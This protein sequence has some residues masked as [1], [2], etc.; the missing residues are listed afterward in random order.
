ML[1]A[2]DLGGTKTLLGLFQRS[3]RARPEE[4]R[5]LEFATLEYPGAE[6][7]IREFLEATGVSPADVEAAS[8]G[9]PGPVID[10]RC[11]P[12]NVDWTVDARSLM[13]ELGL[14]RVT[15]LNDLEA[16]AH[17]VPFLR[18]DELKVLQEGRRD[19]AG[20]AALLAAGTGLGLALLINVDGELRPSASEGGHADF[21]ARTPREIELLIELTRIYGRA[22]TEHVV[23]GPGLVNVARF[24]SQ[25]QSF[26][27]R[28]VSDQAELPSRISQAALSGRCA[29]C[30][31]A[32]TL[33][34]GAF[35]A[36]AGNFAMSGMATGGV[37]IGGGIPPKI[38]PAFETSTFIDAFNAKEP[39][40]GLVKAMPVSIILNKHAGLDGAAVHANSQLR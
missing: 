2:G 15:L 20:N 36:A 21:A 39:L 17:V 33:F 11:K 35:G 31:E 19:P 24:T 8:L 34:V 23:C 37:Y 38:L 10:Q 32:L 27:F 16:M 9:L 3:E 1:L 30:A 4:V 14:P 5:I 29:H 18:E 7:I 22:H 26:V 25:G 40:D 13:S 6:H 28:D 12:T